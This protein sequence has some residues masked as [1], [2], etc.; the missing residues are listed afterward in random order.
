[1][2]WFGDN[3]GWKHEFQTLFQAHMLL[4]KNYE[5]LKAEKEQAAHRGVVFN[6]DVGQV[7]MSPPPSSADEVRRANQRQ[8]DEIRDALKWYRRSVTMQDDISRLDRQ[9]QELRTLLKVPE[10]PKDA[11]PG[12]PGTD[13]PA[14]SGSIPDALFVKQEGSDA[15]KA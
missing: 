6:P 3:E 12:I 14:F 13:Y 10:L 2:K 15:K 11:G 8:A 5:A 7:N 4:V 1:M 9:V